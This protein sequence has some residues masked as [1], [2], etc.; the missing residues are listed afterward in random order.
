[1]QK[2]SN[3]DVMYLRAYVILD[4]SKDKVVKV[5]FKSKRKSASKT[6]KKVGWRIFKIN[7]IKDCQNL[8]KVFSTYREGYNPKD[9]NF[10]EILTSLPLDKFPRGLYK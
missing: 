7:L 10:V 9:T 2:V 4:T 1:M 6:G 3:T 5:Q 8:G